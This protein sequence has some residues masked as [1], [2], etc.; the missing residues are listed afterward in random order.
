MVL[1]RVSSH[2]LVVLECIME[3]EAS[4]LCKQKNDIVFLY[5]V[6]RVPFFH[7]ISC[8]I[9]PPQEWVAHILGPARHCS[10]KNEKQFKESGLSIATGG[11]HTQS[12]IEIFSATVNTTVT[13]SYICYCLS[14]QISWCIDLVF[15]LYLNFLK[16]DSRLQGMLQCCV[17]SIMSGYR[18]DHWTLLLNLV[19]RNTILQ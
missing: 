6:M 1:S 7:F 9:F 19:I 13:V 17:S 18:R 12:Q 3:G 2:L 8:I 10:L 5:V 11:S 16:R 15:L 14:N 4:W